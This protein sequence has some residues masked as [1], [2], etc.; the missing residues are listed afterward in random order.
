MAATS[1][2]ADT[3]SAPAGKRVAVVTGAAQGLGAEI[4]G[5]LRL[6]GFQVVPTDL[7]APQD[8]AVLDVR[9]AV[10][11]SDLAAAVTDRYG[12][13]DVWVN[14]AGVL[15]SGPSWEQPADSQR[16]VLEVN[17]LG[18]MHGTTAALSQMRPRGTGSIV[19][20]VSLAGLS[21]VPGLAAYSASKHA[22][23]SYS[24]STLAELRA[25]GE[26][27]ISISCLC[28]AGIWTPMLHERTEDRWAA[29]PFGGR[30][31]MP[32]DVAARAVGL[33][34]RPRPVTAVPRLMGP[35]SRLSASSPRATILAAPVALR[36]A[37]W[38]QRRNAR[39]LSA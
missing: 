7:T 34:D 30:L 20:I 39:R 35:V 26:R 31:L 12:R 19:N 18:T 17:A 16:Q 3:S 13:L 25:V 1:E 38:Q 37:A 8:G 36:F 10:A 9:D 33:I 23:L 4:V 28:P 24:L 32:A 29:M 5:L 21:P 27:G 2:S 6:R 22:A 14:N 11:C 15:W